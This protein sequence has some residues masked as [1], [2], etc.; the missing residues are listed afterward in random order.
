MKQI[1]HQITLRVTFTA[2]FTGYSET[3]AATAVDLE[4]MCSPNALSFSAHSEPRIVSHRVVKHE[5]AGE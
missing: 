2:H 1:G 3:D 5:T 4:A